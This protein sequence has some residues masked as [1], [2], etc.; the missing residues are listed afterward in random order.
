MTWTRRTRP[1]RA[2]GATVLALVLAAGCTSGSG[3]GSGTTTASSAPSSPGS[4]TP[5]TTTTGTPSRTSPPSSSTTTAAPSCGTRLAAKLTPAQ[6]AGQLLMVGL[7]PTG[8]SRALAAQ[9][10]RQGLGGVIYLGGWTSGSA[11]VRV[12]SERL[13]A[14]AGGDLLV[15]ADQEGGQVQQLRGPGFT[16]MPSA[17]TQATT[18]A[19]T[20]QR[21]VT[22]WS[23]ELLRA[24][25][26][27]NLAPVADTVPTSLGA[28]NQPIG[29]YRRDFAPGSPTTN[30]TYAAAFVRGSL[31]AGVAP[32]A[33]HFPG[34]GRVTG[35][36]DVTTVGTTD[37]TTDRNDPY[38]APFRASIAAGAPLV[39]ISSA[40]YPRIDPDNRAMFSRAVVTGLLRGELGF[41]GVVITDDVGAAQA[42]A[43]IPV[44]QRATRFIAA[45]GDIVLTAEAGQA[46]TMLAAIAAKR[47][48]SPAFAAQVDAAAARVLDLKADLKLVSCD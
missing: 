9:V 43:A 28:A 38:L 5:G 10:R 27:L 33:K 34:L 39:M 6:R 30:A 15:A 8:S 11:S 19:A 48:A 1:F 16:R 17:R 18:S 46:S 21:N 35:N 4:T 42:V 12:V 41:D 25:V 3:G 40:R 22:T 14:A 44:G 36:T 26:N 45:G 7:Q 37:S 13:Q 20:E 23:R 24:G 29:R 47:R 32:T 31:A 2:V